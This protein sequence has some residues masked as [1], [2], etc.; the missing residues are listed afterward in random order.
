[1]LGEDLDPKSIERAGRVLEEL[2]QRLEL[3]SADAA[4]DEPKRR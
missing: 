4:V 3:S 2:R 1:M